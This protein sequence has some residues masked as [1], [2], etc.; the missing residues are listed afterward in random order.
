[1]SGNSGGYS[2]SHI[3]K[4]AAIILQQKMLEKEDQ[5]F[6]EYSQVCAKNAKQIP[7]NET[8]SSKSIKIYL[9]DW[10]QELLLTLSYALNIEFNDDLEYAVTSICGG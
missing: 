10:K 6:Q 4:P 1:M 8:N 7:K 2:S 9:L 5:F 3:L